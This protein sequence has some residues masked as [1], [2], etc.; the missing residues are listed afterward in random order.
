M[1]GRARIM[2]IEKNEVHLYH[3]AFDD[4]ADLPNYQSILSPGE[5]QRGE[6]YIRE[7]DKKRFYTCYTL[8]RKTLADYL[9]INPIDIQ[10]HKNQYG[11][12]FILK[13]QNPLNLQFNIS[14]S[15]N[16]LFF[17]LCLD[18]NIGVDIEETDRTLNVN[19][20]AKQVL[21]DDELRIF[22]QLSDQDRITGFFNAWTRK[23]AFLKAI[24]MG[25]YFPLK[26][27]SVSFVP[28]ESEQLLNIQDDR[29][30]KTVWTLKHFDI[31]NT[32]I[33][34]VAVDILKRKS[35]FQ[36]IVMSFD[37]FSIALR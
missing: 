21:S 22:S 6:R 34:A 12:P 10:F 24:G 32:V 25:M 20:L 27:F 8:L 36:R 18:H 35:K 28:N 11:K 2:K 15:K 29:Y 7:I 19:D 26:N 14:H 13:S 17:G 31:S 1:A 9:S 23:E 33:A 16:N 30:D 5:I 4:T 37:G 3:F